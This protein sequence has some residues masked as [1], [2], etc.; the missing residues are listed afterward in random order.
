MSDFVLLFRSSEAGRRE[1]L[2][3]PERAQKSLQA[4]KAW[5]QGLEAKGHL[6]SRGNALDTS[7]G[8]VRGK[9][10]TVTDG[11]F[12]ESKDI[13]LGF[14][15]ISARDLAEAMELAR[16]C[17]ILEGDGAVEVRPVMDVG[18]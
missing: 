5:I 3:T 15:V 1:A 2:G 4:W 8:V 18:V 6:R 9:K 11:P 14:N 17:P 13:V 16:G 10:R 12:A 7:G